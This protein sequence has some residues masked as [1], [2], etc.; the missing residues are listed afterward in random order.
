VGEFFIEDASDNIMCVETKILNVVTQALELFDKS[1]KE[2]AVKLLNS[3]LEI[4]EKNET[5]QA[6]YDLAMETYIFL[7][8]GDLRKDG[9]DFGFSNIEEI[10]QEIIKLKRVRN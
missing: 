7:I 4:I 5:N 3:F 10:K 8:D 2:E 1:K 6:E 9:R